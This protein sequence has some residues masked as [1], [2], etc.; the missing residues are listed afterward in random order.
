MSYSTPA[1]IRQALVPSLEGEQPTEKTNTAADLSDAQ[2]QDAINEADATIDGYLATHYTTPVIGDPTPHPIDYWSRNIA[3]YNATLAYRQSQD[4][5]DS[6]PVARRFTATMQALQA[7][8]AGKVG[9][10]LPTGE[11]SIAAGVGAAINPV[12]VPFTPVD[13]GYGWRRRHEPFVGIWVGDREI[14]P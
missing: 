1:M 8:A 14:E 7:V 12:T 10:G 5:A 9:L 2:L 13:A 11:S 3:A 4:F 6:D